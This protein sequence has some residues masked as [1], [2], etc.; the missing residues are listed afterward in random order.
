MHG[1]LIWEVYVATAASTRASLINV[2]TF[3]PD[4]LK[5]L[6]GPDLPHRLL[7]DHL[8]IYNLLK[9]K[10]IMVQSFRKINVCWQSSCLLK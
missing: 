10:A 3:F 7:M 6:C 4:Y 1:V 8:C 5:S 2:T 9:L